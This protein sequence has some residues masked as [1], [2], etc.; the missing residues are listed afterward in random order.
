M[1]GWNS[2]DTDFVHATSRT[3]PRLGR[4]TNPPAHTVY[5]PRER[6]DYIHIK[7]PKIMDAIRIKDELSKDPRNHCAPVYEM[8]EIPDD[9]T[10]SILVSPLLRPFKSPRFDTVGE[11]K[12]NSSFIFSL[13]K[14]LASRAF[15]SCTNIILLTDT[16]CVSDCIGPNVM[17]DGSELFPNGFHPLRPDC[18][19]EFTGPAKQMYT[20]TQRPPKYYW[21]DFV[22]SARFN[23]TDR[24][25]RIEPL[26]G[27]DKLAPEFEDPTSED[28]K[29]DPFSTDI[30]YLGNLIRMHFTESRISRAEVP[31]K[32]Y[33]L[34]FLQPLVEEMAQDDPARRRNID[35]CAV[36]LENIMRNQCSWTLRSQVWL[37]DDH[38]LEIVSRLFANWTRRLYHTVKPQPPACP[39]KATGA[40]RHGV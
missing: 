5:G 28:Q 19:R 10:L 14:V 16:H 40:M 8:L 17:M 1:P 36:R 22:N 11:C 37:S 4:T 7:A 30:Y 2:V 6:E 9:E 23:A 15:S 21:I 39:S 35:Q 33:G 29:L 24:S 34:S 12:N 27:T 13:P 18:N 25:P 31:E 38:I 26:Q 20:R 3:G 32:M